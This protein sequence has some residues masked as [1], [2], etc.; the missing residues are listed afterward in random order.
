M[1]ALLA[2]AQHLAKHAPTQSQRDAAAKHAD[3]VLAMAAAMLTS[4]P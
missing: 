3:A 1:Q 4:K 2:N